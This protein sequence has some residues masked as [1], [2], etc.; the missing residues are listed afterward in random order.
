MRRA[1]LIAGLAFGA[2]VLTAE[3][4]DSPATWGTSTG[5]STIMN[6]QL[7]GTN[8]T[9]ST[10][11]YRLF[12]QGGAGTSCHGDAE[13]ECLGYA[14]ILAPEGAGLEWLRIWFYDDSLGSDLHYALMRNC[15]PPGGPRTEEVLVEGVIP[16]V[17]GD[18]YLEHSFLGVGVNNADCGYTMRLRLTD[19]GEPPAGFAIRVRK[20]AIGWKRQV[21]P[22]PPFATFDDVPTSHP[23]HQF[24]EALVRSGI[25]AGCGGGNYCPDA[26][27]TRGQMAVFLAKAL[28]LQWPLPLSE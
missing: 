2:R 18:A 25:T 23:F 27:L 22:A 20:M 6:Y 10:T 24:V 4:P 8:A 28:G 21:S 15:E 5:Y 14:Q 17:D 16:H 13:A 19:P 11:A 1:S 7:Q 12:H 26:P 9:G 3:P